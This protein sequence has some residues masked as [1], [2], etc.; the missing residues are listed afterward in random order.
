MGFHDE[1]H[2]EG[3]EANYEEGDE[4]EDE[5]KEAEFLEGEIVV[6]IEF[7]KTEAV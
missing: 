3:G 6:G 5:K 1:D 2:E 4:E 7:S